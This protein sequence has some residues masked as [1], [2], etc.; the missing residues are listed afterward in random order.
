[1]RCN[2]TPAKY[3]NLLYSIVFP[4]FYSKEL[5]ALYT[6]EPLSPAHRSRNPIYIAVAV[7]ILMI[8]NVHETGAIA[9]FWR[10][11]DIFRQCFHRFL[12][13]SILLYIYNKYINSI[14]NDSR[15][16]KF[17]LQ[18][19]SIEWHNK[20][21]A[22]EKRVHKTQAIR[23]RQASKSKTVVNSSFLV[24]IWLLLLLKHCL[25]CNI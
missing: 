17:S 8:H 10:T 7:H 21:T 20:M 22:L 24:F 1:M 25:T 3:M 6:I 5:S 11:Y 18:I 9:L 13:F 2:W 19:Q 16:R 4:L 23:G 15:R 14:R 12:S